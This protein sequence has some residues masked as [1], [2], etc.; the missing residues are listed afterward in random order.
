MER[1]QPDTCQRLDQHLNVGVPPGVRQLDAI[2]KRELGQVGR[3][4]FGPRHLRAL[5][6][7]GNDGNVALQRRGCFEADEIVRVVEPYPPLIVDRIEPSLADHGQKDA[8][9]R[10]VVIDGLAKVAAG[11]N[12]RHIDE[13][14]V[15][16]EVPGEIVEQ[17]AGL[18]FGIFAAI[19]DEDRSHSGGLSHPNDRADGRGAVFP[20]RQMDRS[21][22]DQET[23]AP[24]GPFR[25]SRVHAG[26]NPQ[27]SEGGHVIVSLPVRL[28]K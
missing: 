23:V 24:S 7:H 10:D 11:F 2:A 28:G 8:T 5:D 14:G 6:Q 27:V 18:S 15:R 4:L 17:A 13:H 22:P 26:K 12:R 21:Q 1:H 19:A 25:G 3:Q 9:G 16:A 20:V